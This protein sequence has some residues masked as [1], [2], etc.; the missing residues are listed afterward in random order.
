MFKRSLVE[1]FPLLLFARLVGIEIPHLRYILV[2][3]GLRF[4]MWRQVQGHTYISGQEINIPAKPAAF[5]A[6]ATQQD[7]P[8]YPR[9]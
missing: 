3:P 6:F 7:G 4:R 2:R 5:G 8:G 1:Y 9:W